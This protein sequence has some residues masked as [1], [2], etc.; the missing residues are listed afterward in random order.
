[1]TDPLLANLL[2]P[3]VL[4]FAL[5]IAAKLVRSDLSLPKDIYTG[6]SIYLLFALGLKGGV[7]LSRTSWDAI[8]LPAA[9]TLLLGVVTPL[10]AYA[11]L[12]R[13]GRPPAAGAGGGAARRRAGSGWGRRARRA[14]CCGGR[15]GSPPRTRRGSPRTAGRSRR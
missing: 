1:M 12:R 9:V 13:A 6:L 2:S 15:G 3:L 7:E 8:A 14:R 4:A 5:G 10:T 11:A